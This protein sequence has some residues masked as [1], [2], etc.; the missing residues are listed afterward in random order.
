MKNNNNFFKIKRFYKKLKSFL[1]NKNT[2]M[3]IPHSEKKI[4][5]LHLSN[6]NLSGITL[7]LFLILSMGL[8]LSVN[9]SDRMSD[10]HYY[11]SENIYY[12]QQIGNIHQVLPNIAR[13]QNTLFGK[14][15]KLFSVLGVENINDSYINSISNPIDSSSRFDH[16]N[17]KMGNISSYIKSTRALFTQIPSIFPLVTKSFWFSSR[18]GWRMHPISGARTFHTGQDIATLPGTPILAAADGIVKTSGWS[19]PYGNMVYLLHESGFST[20]YAHMMRTAVY[21]G[22]SVKKGQ[23]IGF[24]GTTGMSTGYHLHYEVVLN[25]ELLDPFVYLYLDRFGK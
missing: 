10:Y 12:Q 23:V 2:F 20:R 13:S 3:F 11:Y 7:I 5:S 18:F 17:D 8:F 22:E 19:G 25:D 9:L 16:I 15:D 4:F 6:F 21:L 24:V 14:L 1:N